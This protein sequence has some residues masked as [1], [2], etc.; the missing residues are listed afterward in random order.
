MF[1]EGLPSRDHTGQGE[2]RAEATAGG[3]QR[4]EATGKGCVIRKC[5][6]EF[7]RT[8]MWFTV[9]TVTYICGSQEGE[10]R[11][12]RKSCCLGVVR[13]NILC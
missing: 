2:E 13:Q 5:S 11:T 9:E 6:Y 7:F 3:F 10:S 8:C 4:I 1:G 12:P